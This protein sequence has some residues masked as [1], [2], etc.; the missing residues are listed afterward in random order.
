[1][2]QSLLNGRFVAAKYALVFAV[3][4][5]MLMMLASCAA[6]P[7]EMVD[8]P[9]EKGRV[10]G[11]WHGLVHGFIVLFTFIVSLFSDSVRI[12][13][14]HNSGNWYNFGFVLG[15]M[16]FF[17]GGGGGASRHTKC[18]WGGSKEQ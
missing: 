5:L 12:Y 8:S 14:V 17:G 18:R 1:V 13:E 9:D 15:I 3:G 6:G 7:N 10:A 11:F 2:K 16:I 4:A